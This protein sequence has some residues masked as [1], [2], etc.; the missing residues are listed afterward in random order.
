MIMLR[1]PHLPVDRLLI[2]LWKFRVLPTAVDISSYCL[3][4]GHRKGTDRFRTDKG[5]SMSEAILQRRK[6]A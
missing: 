4:F 2:P 6:T 5:R 1:F 3:N